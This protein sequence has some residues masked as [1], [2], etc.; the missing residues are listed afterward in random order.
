MRPVNIF[1]SVNILVIVKQQSPAISL[2]LSYVSLEMKSV[3]SGKLSSACVTQL[4]T[5]NIFA[6][7]N[8]HILNY[9]NFLNCEGSLSNKDKWRSSIK[10]KFRSPH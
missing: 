3:G 6:P 2:V 8:Y 1:G 9:N 4:K 5:E 10:T 7:K